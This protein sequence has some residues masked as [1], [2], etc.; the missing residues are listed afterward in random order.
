ME[1]LLRRVMRMRQKRYRDEW[2]GLFDRIMFSLILLIV[3]NHFPSNL[4]IALFEMY[5][6]YYLVLTV[7]ILLNMLYEKVQWRS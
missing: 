4:R 3:L 5:L 6:L 7:E 2:G 1:G